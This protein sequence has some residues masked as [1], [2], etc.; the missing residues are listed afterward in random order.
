[1]TDVEQ[2]ERLLVDGTLCPT[3]NRAGEGRQGEGLY[4]GKRHRAGGNTLVVADR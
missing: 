2:A 3:G 4:S 1:M